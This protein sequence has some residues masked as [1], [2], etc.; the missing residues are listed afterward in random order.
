MKVLITY[1][2]ITGNTKKLAEGIYKGLEIKDKE[3]LELKSV[4]SFDSYDLIILGYWAYR[5]TC[6]KDVLRI[7]KDI[8]NKNLFLFAT[9]AFYP[10]SQ[11]AYNVLNS[12]TELLENQGNNVLSRYICTGGLD[13]KRV[14]DKIDNP[15]KYKHPITM[16]KKI[17]YDVLKKH[18]TELDIECAVERF[19]DRL[20]IIRRINEEE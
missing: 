18:P 15:E 20:E 7:I 5:G 8:N 11:H 17:R 2:S 19:N 16:E 1:A 10:D 13:P 3:I 9:L 12:V 14:Q 4:K 6:S